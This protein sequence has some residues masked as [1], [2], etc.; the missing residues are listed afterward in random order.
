LAVYLS[1]T[2]DNDQLDAHL[3]YFIIIIIII[4][5]IITMCSFYAS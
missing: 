4:I 2:L 1:I 3:L 5:I